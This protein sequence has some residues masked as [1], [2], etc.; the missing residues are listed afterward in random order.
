MRRVCPQIASTSEFVVDQTM[1]FQTSNYPV[2]DFQNRGPIF[3]DCY[4][5]PIMSLVN[6]A[7]RRPRVVRVFGRLSP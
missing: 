2:W 7:N 3:L 4:R 6:R 1:A 5:S